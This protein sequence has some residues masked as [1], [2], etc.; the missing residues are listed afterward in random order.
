VDIAIGYENLDERVYARRV[1]PEPDLKYQMVE[2]VKNINRFESTIYFYDER[3]EGSNTQK[4][5]R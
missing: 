2:V 4:R 1:N 5:M 3:F